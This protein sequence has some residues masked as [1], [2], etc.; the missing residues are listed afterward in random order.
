M[1]SRSHPAGNCN[2]RDRRCTLFEFVPPFVALGFRGSIAPDS[3]LAWHQR[4]CG[5]ARELTCRPVR[6]ILF[7]TSTGI[8]NHRAL[9]KMRR[10]RNRV[11]K[12]TQLTPANKRVLSSKQ[13]SSH[14]PR[15]LLSPPNKTALGS[16]KTAIAPNKNAVSSK[17]N[18]S[19]CRQE[20]SQFT[21]GCL[22]GRTR[23]L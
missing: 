9:S 20:R 11:G 4:C 13:N 19:Q 5:W 17:Q 15:R 10:P 14:L 2:D 12:T 16:N 3:W 18:S 7:C 1:R 6:G 22:T 23:V 8:D 21:T